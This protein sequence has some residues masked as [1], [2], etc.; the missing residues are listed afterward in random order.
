VRNPWGHG[1]WVLDWSD[2]PKDDN[3][4]YK[5]LYHNTDELKKYYDAKAE[6]A[7]KIKGKTKPIPYKIGE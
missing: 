1:E 6:E 5:S 4:D 2:K 3:E 7:R